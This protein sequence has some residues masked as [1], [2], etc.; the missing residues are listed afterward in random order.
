[1]ITC[2]GETGCCPHARS[3]SF[4]LFLRCAARL[5][6]HCREATA[7][8]TPRGSGM[9]AVHLRQR[10]RLTVQK[11]QAEAYH[12]A[13]PRV[14]ITANA[15]RTHAASRGEK[16]DSVV[17]TEFFQLDDEEDYELVPELV[18]GGSCAAAGSTVDGRAF[19]SRTFCAQSFGSSSWQR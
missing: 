2:D 7:E 13:A 11:A 16:S 8:T 3:G 5:R 12:H 19:S 9:S 17:E 18:S 1:M 14:Q 15:R 4:V 6:P 10:E